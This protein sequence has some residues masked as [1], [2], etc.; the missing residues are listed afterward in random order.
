M[1]FLRA[2]NSSEWAVLQGRGVWLRPPLMNDYGPWAELRAQGR[3]HLGPWEP[4]WPRDDLTKSA[5]RRRIRHYQREARDD[6]GYAF[7]LFEADS[8]RLLGG[9]TLSNVRRGVTQSAMLG[10][11]L[12]QP[13]V[14]RGLMTSAVCAILPHAFEQ[15]RL[16]RIEAAV[17]PAN[18]RS[19]GVL[20]R[21]GFLEEG[22]A[23]RY[24]KINGAWQD[25]LVFAILAEDWMTREVQP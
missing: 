1:A 3:A 13:Y 11:W 5:Y 14:G 18:A 7:L 20:K 2:G 10:Y 12:G 8:E 17:Q 23:R 25:H 6:L 4:A 24:L 21:A 15:L 19:I 9:L 16:H 22:L